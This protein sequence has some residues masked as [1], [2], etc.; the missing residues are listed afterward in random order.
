ME[1]IKEKYNDITYFIEE[2]KGHYEREDK[3]YWNAYQ[4]ILKNRSLAH[5]VKILRETYLNK[6]F[7]HLLEKDILEINSIYVTELLSKL[8][9]KF[10]T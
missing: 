1:S 9:S 6:K 7:S 10:N 8:T 2:L 3:N 4:L 5:D